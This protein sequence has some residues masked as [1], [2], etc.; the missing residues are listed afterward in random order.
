MSFTLTFHSL[1]EKVPSHHQKIL[2]FD[3]SVDGFGF[4]TDELNVGE[5]FYRWDDG[6]GTSWIYEDGDSKLDSDEDEQVHLKLYIE[7]NNMASEY[8][9]VSDITSNYAKAIYWTDFK[10]YVNAITNATLKLKS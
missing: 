1:Q 6:N 9:P 7:H 5:V 3:S 4:I 8:G 10:E 2:F